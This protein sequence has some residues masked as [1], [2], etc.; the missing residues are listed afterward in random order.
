MRLLTDNPI[1]SAV[2][3]AVGAAALYLV[4]LR[5]SAAP[6]SL[7]PF[8]RDSRRADEGVERRP[9]VRAE[10]L[11]ARFSAERAAGAWDAIVV[12]SGVGGLV[13]GAILSR[14]GKRVLVLEQ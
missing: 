9:V 14:A 1:Y 10:A 12:G 2:V 5:A 8:A 13:A 7:N 6:A 11:R 3:A 4:A